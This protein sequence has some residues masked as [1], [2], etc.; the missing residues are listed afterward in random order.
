MKLI[1]AKPER[2]V[3][4]TCDGETYNVPTNGTI[5]TW[6]DVQCPL[7][8]FDLLYYQGSSR[9]FVFCPNCFTNPPFE[10]MGKG[11]GCNRCTNAACQYSMPSNTIG[12][13]SACTSNGSL[14]LDQGS[15]PPTW[16]VYCSR[17]P[18]SMSLFKEASRVSVVADTCTACQRR[19]LK[20]KYPP[21][22]G[23]LPNSLTEFKGCLWCAEE[24]APIKDAINSYSAGF[25]SANSSREGGAIHYNADQS[26]RGFRGGGRGGRGGRGGGRGRGRGR[27]RGGG[28]GDRGDREDREFSRDR[29]GGGGGFGGGGRVGPNSGG[30]RAN[31]RGGRGGRGG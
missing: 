23:K 26:N 31:Q 22:K 14:V 17:C 9:G 24:L 5:K 21:G 25:A 2:L 29:G 27:G 12:P 30:G 3:C 20:L 8:Q 15:G 16:K 7:D 1:T 18:F 28:G 6:K 10:D 13:C 4:P 11:S 19:L